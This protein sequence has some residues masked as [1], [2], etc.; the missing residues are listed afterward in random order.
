V[1]DDTL[2]AV[3]GVTVGHWTD[4]AAATGVTVIDFPEPNVAA[5]DVRGGAPGTRETALL[6]PGKKVEMIQAITLAGGSA[7][8]LAAA[9][10]VIASLEAA[11]RGH[12]T[13]AGR[14]PIVPAAIIF[15]LMIGDGS[16]RPDP[17]AGAAAFSARSPDPVRMGTVGAGTGA[18]VAGWR[19]RDA[20]RKG[21]LGSAAVTVG[22]AVVGALAVVNAVGDVF[23]LEGV[24]LTGGPHVPALTPQKPTMPLEQT[25]LICLATNASLRRT[26]LMHLGVRAHDALGACLRPAHTRH[27]GDIAFVV[28]CGEIEGDPD[29]LG[30]AAFVAVGRSVERAVTLAESLAGVPAIGGAR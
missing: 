15:D 8:G 28:S 1:A 20:V 22:D 14:I 4:R 25:V 7:F 27:D 30:E 26:E 21:G 16:R 24:P 19:G 3:P 9:D 2:T 11:G 10:G 17:E 13:M 23:T 12:E 6:A 29:A 5:V 18:V